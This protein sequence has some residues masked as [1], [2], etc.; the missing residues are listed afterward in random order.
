MYSIDFFHNKNLTDS[1]EIVNVIAKKLNIPSSTIK[2]VSIEK[3]SLDA[4][5]K[6]DIKWFYRVNFECTKTLKRGVKRVIPEKVPSL[7]IKGLQNKKVVIVGMGP[8]GIFA[9][10]RLAM[11]GAKCII[12]ERG[13]KI[14]ER[15]RDVKTFFTTRTLNEESNIQFGEGGA[16]TFSDGK[17]TT[18]TKSPYHSFVFDEFI[19]AGAPEEIRYLSNPHIG[20]DKLR[21]VI[22]NL[23][24]KL[25]SLGVEIYFNERFEKLI[26][27]KDRN[28]RGIITSTREIFCDSVILATGYSARDTY[29]ILYEQGVF[30]EPKGFAMGFRMELPQKKID[31][32][33]YG[34]VSKSLP[35]AEFFLN[36]HF[37]DKG[38]SVYTFCMCP[39]GIIVPACSKKGFLVLNG[40]SYYK[41]S[42]FFGNSAVVISLNPEIWGKSIFGGLE[43]QKKVELD[44]FVAGGRDYTAPAVTTKD[45]IEERVSTSLRKASYPFG[46]KPFPIW[47]IFKEWKDFFKKAIIDFDRKM[48]GIIS[49]DVLLLASETRTSTPI[50]IKRGED[51]MSV[52]TKNL[53][54]CGEGAGYA[55]GIVTSAVDGLKIVEKII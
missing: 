29:E 9:C 3:K 51:G 5:K 42:G 48:K 31:E 1:K 41:R 40:M 30:M 39:G 44:S 13:S 43:L 4:R 8:C 46:V 22:K 27:D 11:N 14:E 55:G 49:E 2:N 34:K 38:L 53:Y 54:P 7:I 26:L 52:N 28:V 32:I 15:I 25:L 21:V 24:N 17:L 47:E 36:C 12:I 6:K 37:K 16:G 19:K 50:R 20:T 23:R 33:Q 45:F 10:L 18:R 35:P